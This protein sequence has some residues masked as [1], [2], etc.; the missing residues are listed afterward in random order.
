MRVRIERRWVRRVWITVE[1]TGTVVVTA[2]PR[3][4]ESTLQRLIERHRAWIE[5]QRERYRTM[6]RIR[7]HPGQLLYR[8]QVYR[9]V[10]RQRLGEQV[11]IYPARAIIESGENLL[12]PA[13]QRQWYSNEAERLLRRRV[14]QLAVRFGFYYW[15]FRVG[16]YV[17]AWGYCSADGTLT[18]DWRIAK[19][20]PHVM[21]YLIVH[22]LLHTKIPHHGPRFWRRLE[23]LLP[24]YRRAVEWLRTYGRW[25]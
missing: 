2:S 19:L 8:G 25:V 17:S 14:G 16:D 5:R 7:L 3:Y 21:D 15:R 20:P 12:D 9:F 13:I 18:F 23:D 4:A 11:L 10:C 22:E 1:H 24:N 6:D